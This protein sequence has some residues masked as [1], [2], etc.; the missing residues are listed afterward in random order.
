MS[1]A[2]GGDQP[3]SIYTEVI[4]RAKELGTGMFQL[5]QAKA[6][7]RTGTTL[8][9][10]PELRVPWKS[11]ET[12]PNSA[13]M[14]AMAGP[15]LVDAGGYSKSD[16]PMISHGHDHGFINAVTTA[17]AQ[18][19]PLALRP[20]H[21][22]LL[23]LQGVATHVDLH[24]EELRQKW[25]AH[26]GKE[27]LVV[28]CDDFVKG[29]ANPWD[30]TVHGRADCFAAQITS[31][32]VEGVAGV[33]SPTFTG[34]L[35]TQTESIAQQ[36]VVMDI[37]KNYFTYKCSTMC[38]FP[39]ITLEGSPQDWQ[40]VRQHAEQLLTQQ[41]QPE[42]SASWGKAL[43]PVLDKFVTASATGGADERFWNS[44]CKRGGT[45]GSGSYTWFNGWMNVLFPYIDR[46]PN[47][48]CV[49]Y[50]PS[51]G[52][53]QEGREEKYYCR[54]RDKMPEGVQGPDVED[55][56]NGRSE[57]P[58]LWEYLG[59]SIPLKFVSGFV[60][61]TQDPKT[62]TIS[63]HVGWFIAAAEEAVD[64]NE[65]GRGAA[66]TDALRLRGIEERMLAGLRR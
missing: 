45:R 11:V 27:T 5:T 56:P 61:A 63:P 44:M 37:C 17:F 33:L 7:G 3:S 4:R 57:A 62:R 13:A 31:H 48:Y 39:S 51:A 15:G 29:R 53:V 41:C 1:D 34:A 9:V 60:G 8:A 42:F 65:R 24:A 21:L 28:R 14:K 12:V 64:D 66:Y 52:Y 35:T 55:F 2:A 50:S 22:W 46:R 32:L 23:V 49:P 38:G 59:E 58:V 18:H 26:Q 25:V 6:D 54:F 16:D 36:M 19:Y 10:T 30:T 43:L 20:Q 47:R 40:L